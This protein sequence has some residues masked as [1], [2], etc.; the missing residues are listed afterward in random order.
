LFS[1]VYDP[2]GI[3]LVDM[4]EELIV[5]TE[6]YIEINM[7]KVG[8]IDV[9]AKI[10]SPLGNIVPVSVESTNIRRRFKIIPKE[11]GPHKISLK[12]S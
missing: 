3:E 1:N 6:N 8:H 9:D 7:T 12:N 10:Y 5:G 4:P 2:R 11:I